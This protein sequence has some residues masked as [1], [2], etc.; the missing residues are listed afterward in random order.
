[1]IALSCVRDVG[2]EVC[3][4]PAE[5]YL[6]LRESG[7]SR[8]PQR[9]ATQ[10]HLEHHQHQSRGFLYIA[11]VATTH[12]S[13]A[14]PRTLALKLMEVFHPLPPR[15]SITN[16]KTHHLTSHLCRHNAQSSTQPTTPPP[17]APVT[18]CC[19]NVCAVPQW[20]HTTPAASSDSRTCKRLILALRLSMTTRRIVWNMSRSQSREE[21]VLLR[22]RG[23]L[24]VSVCEREDGR[25]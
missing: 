17:S 23:R 11:A 25:G 15:T 10:A 14:V 13:M 8:L 20:L 18:V 22:R 7:N 19:A 12:L 1:M 16:R 21:R 5:K 3:S 24:L 9:A 2:C 4:S 6:W